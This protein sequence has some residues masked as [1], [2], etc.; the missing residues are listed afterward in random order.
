M[1]MGVR[2]G[3]PRWATSLGSSL[4]TFDRH[5]FGRRY[6]SAGFTQAPPTWLRVPTTVE[7]TYG[8]VASVLKAA[9]ADRLIVSSPCR[10]IRLPV[11]VRAKV[12]PLTVDQVAAIRRRVGERWARMVVAAAGSGQRSGELRGLTV[13][14]VFGQSDGTAVLRVDRQLVGVEASSVPVFGPPKTPA[15]DRR[16]PVPASVAQAISRQLEEFGP[17]AGGV[18]FASRHRRGLS[19]S[20][21][22]DVW[23]DATAGMAAA[24]VG[25]A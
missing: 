3:R 14:R 6:T 17:G 5:Y 22:G 8:Y 21:A 1:Q 9:V 12:L 13:D 19:R 4:A 15:A 2:R 16:A 10:G 7:V 20:R 23:R 25:V 18:V 24:A 11:L